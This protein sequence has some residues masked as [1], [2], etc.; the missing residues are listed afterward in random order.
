MKVSVIETSTGK[1]NKITITSDQDRQSKKN[2]KGMLNEVKMY[3]N[4]DNREM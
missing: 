4:E 1:E 3:H 2:I